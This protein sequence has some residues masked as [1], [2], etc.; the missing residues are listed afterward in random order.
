MASTSH[1]SHQHRHDHHDWDS[2]DYVSNWASGQDQKEKA[3]QEPFR[4]LAQT[5]PYDKQLPI[6]ILDVGAGY[7]ALTQF[8]SELFFKGR[9]RLPGRVRRDGEAR[10]GAHAAP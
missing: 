4:V 9:S 10:P 6:R 5:I 3:R 7:G 2:P 8:P 1:A